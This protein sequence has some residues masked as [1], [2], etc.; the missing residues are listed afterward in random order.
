MLGSASTA[1][2]AA[3]RSTA[4]AATDPVPVP[5]SSTR[6]PAATWAASSSAGT[7]CAHSG[8]KL[9]A[10]ASARPAQACRS[11]ASNGVGWAS[12]C[13]RLRMRPNLAPG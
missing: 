9:P 7:V 1:V 11:Y 2:T 12:G 13:G 3:P 8:A 4:A 6:S 5:T 10:K